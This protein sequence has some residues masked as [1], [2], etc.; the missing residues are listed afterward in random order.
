MSPVFVM[1]A[2]AI[3]NVPT[4]FSYIQWLE[5]FASEATWLVPTVEVFHIGEEYLD[6]AWLTLPE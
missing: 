1:V 2:L 6:T 4:G 5:K 3:R